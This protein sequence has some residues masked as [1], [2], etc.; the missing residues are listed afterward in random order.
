[1]ITKWT[2]TWITETIL[3][4]VG[5]QI[6]ILAQLVFNVYGILCG[7]GLLQMKST[8]LIYKSLSVLATI[9]QQYIQI[10]PNYLLNQSYPSIVKQPVVK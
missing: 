5:F 10:H 7:S 4:F 8:I 9:F 2:L 3:D 1:M 6:W